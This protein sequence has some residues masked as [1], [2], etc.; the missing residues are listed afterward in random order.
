MGRV[1]EQLSLP[2]GGV[3]ARFPAP[4]TRG[5]DS[6]LAEA[7]WRAPGRHT[8]EHKD[9][10][11]PPKPAGEASPL[12]AGSR[13]LCVHGS[14]PSPCLLSSML[15][16]QPWPRAE[17]HPAH[18]GVS[19]YPPGKLE[20]VRPEL[21]Q[22]LHGRARPV[23]GL[24]PVR[25][26][27]VQRELLALAATM[28]KRVSAPGRPSVRSALAPNILPEWTRLL[29]VGPDSGFHVTEGGLYIAPRGGQGLGA[30]VTK[31]MHREK[32]AK[33]PGANCRLFWPTCHRRTLSSARGN[34]H[35]PLSLGDCLAPS[36]GPTR[37][38]P[39]GDM[40]PSAP[41]Q[42]LW[43]RKPLVLSVASIGDAFR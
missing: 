28:E 20:Q 6:P 21:P 17:R 15:L 27:A 2:A 43:A 31:D 3:G 11:V 30:L 8:P 13:G 26:M 12:A 33:G 19:H 22:G 41:R 32:E 39:Q 25:D 37:R 4:S 5:G 38:T 23:L 40:G 36:L 1:A 35:A 42:T 29:G 10:V 24:L 18:Q 16:T 9:W 14:F 34:L 7:R